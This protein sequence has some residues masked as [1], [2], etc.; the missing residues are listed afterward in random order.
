[1]TNG[2]MERNVRTAVG[3]VMGGLPP[4]EIE[5]LRQDASLRAVLV[6]G[7]VDAVTAM[8]VDDGDDA[9]GDPGSRSV[10]DLA[11]KAAWRAPVELVGLLERRG[12]TRLAGRSR[13]TK[14]ARGSAW[15]GSAYTLW[16]RRGWPQ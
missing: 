10:H 12:M 9:D 14:T 6:R 5:R 3:D 16:P 4:A 8:M 15:V 2:D 1:M 13:V 11:E 7:I